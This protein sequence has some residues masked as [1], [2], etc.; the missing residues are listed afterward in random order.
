MVMTRMS[1]PMMM[2][3]MMLIVRGEGDEEE[4]HPAL[5][6]STSISIP[7]DPPIPS[8]SNTEVARLLDIPT[9]PPSP[10]SPW[11]SPL[12]QIPSPPL[13]SIL[14]PL[15]VSSPPPASPTYLLGYRAAMIRLRAVALS[16]SR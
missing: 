9:P 14:S 12:P 15:P 7:D 8:G 2:R 10:L 11:S 16:T 13:P 3:M 1:H 6:D 5:A 4:E